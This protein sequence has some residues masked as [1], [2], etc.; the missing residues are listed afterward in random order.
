[1]VGPRTEVNLGVAT[2]F[3][4]AT[5]R[6]EGCVKLN[7]HRARLLPVYEF[8]NSITGHVATH[9]D[10]GTYDGF[11][12]PTIAQSADHITS[13]DIDNEMLTV[14]RQRPEIQ[15]LIATRRLD[16]VEMNA[17]DIGERIPPS[18][19]ERVSCNEVF[20]AG[21]KGSNADVL[22]VFQ[23]IFKVLTPG[24]VAIFTMKNDYAD[25][26]LNL[27]LGFSDGS[28]PAKDLKGETISKTNL[29]AISQLFRQ[30]IDWYGQL[31][32]R[33]HKGKRPDLPFI[34]DRNAHGGLSW[35]PI[36]L[37]PRKI[38]NFSTERPLYMVGVLRKLHDISLQA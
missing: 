16:L 19:V 25:S 12:I 24:G 32:A 5:L 22:K 33:L 2:L 11:A 13:I 26:L 15:E 4:P 20:G 28:R 14:A 7:P 6:R 35:D 36:E 38:A 3:P 18:S 17:C 10:I 21:F 1:M 37:Q 9:L 29:R 27:M 31:T 23:G 8:L 30:R 34:V